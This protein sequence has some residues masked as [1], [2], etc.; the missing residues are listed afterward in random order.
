MHPPETSCM[1][2]AIVMFLHCASV[3]ELGA[4]SMDVEQKRDHSG[5]EKQVQEMIAYN[6]DWNNIL[7][8][9]LKEKHIEG[10]E[11]KTKAEIWG[12]LKVWQDM[13]TARM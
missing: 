2:L 12:I 7:K 10:E 4:N 13:V 8:Y 9:I 1:P 5:L 6:M 3:T 11:E